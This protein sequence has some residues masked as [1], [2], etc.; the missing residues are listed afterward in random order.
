[1]NAKNHKFLPIHACHICC[2]CVSIF[3]MRGRRRF[4]RFN[5]GTLYS[6]VLMRDDPAVCVCHAIEI[7]CAATPNCNCCVCASTPIHCVRI[8]V[9]AFAIGRNDMKEMAELQLYGRC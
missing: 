9:D 1:M 6:V 5:V 3:V 7:I 2:V 8:G 4:H